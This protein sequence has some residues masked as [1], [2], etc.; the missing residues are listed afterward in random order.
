MTSAH[1]QVV[2]PKLKTALTLSDSFC[3]SLLHT[4]TN[5]LQHLLC[6]LHQGLFLRPVVLLCVYFNQRDF[7][8]SKSHVLPTI[9]LLVICIKMLVHQP[10]SRSD[11]ESKYYEALAGYIS[12]NFGNHW[13]LMEQGKCN[14]SK[15]SRE[16]SDV[17][18]SATSFR[19][20]S[21][22]LLSTAVTTVI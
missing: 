16:N 10:H 17:F 7:S 22:F 12:H 2:T 14:I 5:S 21:V 8:Q 18:C 19:T 20:S 9:K 3:Q 1:H 11:W 4:A 13:E 15:V 6:I